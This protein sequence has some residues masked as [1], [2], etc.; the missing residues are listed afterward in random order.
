MIG[1]E[2]TGLQDYETQQNGFPSHVAEQLD[3]KRRL[4]LRKAREQ[5]NYAPGFEYPDYR[6]A[7]TADADGRDNGHVLEKWPRVTRQRSITRHPHRVLT[8]LPHKR[9]GFGYK[10]PQFK[11]LSSLKAPRVTLDD[12]EPEVEIT[13]SGPDE[14]LWTFSLEEPTNIKEAVDLTFRA[15]EVYEQGGMG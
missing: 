6:N 10:D 13:I 7:P 5:I 2:R 11:T 12:F 1:R 14:E 3:S 4:E 8:R 15:W 9:S